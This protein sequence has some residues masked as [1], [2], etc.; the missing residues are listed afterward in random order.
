MKVKLEHAGGD[1]EYRIRITLQPQ[2]GFGKRSSSL[3]NVTLKPASQA[4]IQPV[5]NKNCEICKPELISGRP[6]HR[7]AFAGI[8]EDGQY[9][10]TS[11]YVKIMSLA[12]EGGLS[13][14]TSDGPEQIPLDGLSPDQ[15]LEWQCSAGTF[16]GTSMGRS[17][18]YLTPGESELSKSPITITL[19]ASGRSAAIR[20]FWLLR[21]PSVMHC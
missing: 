12:D 11:E 16:V 15:D 14:L 4:N 17:V 6:D 3:A 19:Q 1:K 5:G 10:M 20:R 13:W 18:I 8:A 2:E 7:I 21:R 9:M